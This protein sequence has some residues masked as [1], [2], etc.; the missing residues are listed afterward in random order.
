MQFQD[1]L[2]AGQILVR[3]AL[4]SPN[5]SAGTTGWAVKLDGSAEFNNVTIRSTLQSGNFVTGVSGWQLLQ[6]GHAE[7]NDVTIRGAT[8]AGGQALYYNG[9]PAAG[10]LIVSISGTAGTD[11]FGNTYVKG[12]GAY[13]AAGQV[14]AKDSAGN[15]TVMSGNV[16]GG[17]LL[18]T[19]PGLSLKLGLV[20]GDQASI[21]ALD[22][23]S[24]AGFSLLLTSPSTVVGGIPGT[25]FSQVKLTGNDAGPP[26]VSLQAGTLTFNATT[27]DSVGEIDTYAGN[28]WHTYSPVTSGTGGATFSTKT[29]YWRR[30]GDEIEFTAYAV[31]NGAGSGSTVVTITAPTNIDRTTR[32][33]V[34]AHLESLTTG[35]NGSGMAV[36]FNTGSGNVFD[37]IRNSTNGS[38]TGADVLSGCIITIQGRYRGA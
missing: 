20:T 2:A 26:D 15:S 12:I 10:N 5:Y 36:A 34:P 19:L 13:G 38:I 7:F 9:T 11:A 3:P 17:G 31:C 30:I 21:G 27:M 4:Q 24:H 29:G 1:E 14:V 28:I 23:G 32:Q 8:V 16:G 6:S 25:D 35:N 37:R 18:A 33:V 22:D